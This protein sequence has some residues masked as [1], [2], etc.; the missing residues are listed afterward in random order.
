ML[1][2]ETFCPFQSWE[3]E[4]RKINGQT[5][6]AVSQRKTPIEKVDE[7]AMRLTTFHQQKALFLQQ[8]WD[9]LI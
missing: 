6:W 2:E 1:A 4:K 9:R 3:D 8:E 5:R 7:D